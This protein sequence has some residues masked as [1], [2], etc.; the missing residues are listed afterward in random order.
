LT[1]RQFQ[2]LLNR[3]ADAAARHRAALEALSDAF[4]KRYGVH[5]SDVDADFIIDA[6]DLEGHRVTVEECD[7]E[8]V[9]AMERSVQT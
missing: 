1:P 2:R 5:Y 4:V 6:V 3:A 8:M 9:L 7:R